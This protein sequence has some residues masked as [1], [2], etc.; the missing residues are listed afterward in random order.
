MLLFFFCK[1]WQYFSQIC[2][3]WSKGPSL[4]TAALKPSHSGEFCLPIPAS[5]GVSCSWSWLLGWA[6]FWRRKEA[7]SIRPRSTARKRGVWPRGVQ[8]STESGPEAGQQETVRRQLVCRTNVQRIQTFQCEFQNGLVCLDGCFM[9]SSPTSAVQLWELVS[10]PD[11]QIFQELLITWKVI[12]CTCTKRN[13]V[14]KIEGS[15][16]YSEQQNSPGCR[17]C[18]LAYLALSQWRSCCWLQTRAPS[19]EEKSTDKT[20]QGNSSLPWPK[21]LGKSSNIL[22]KWKQWTIRWTYKYK[23]HS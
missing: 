18:I 3:L 21:W 2:T 20:V 13:T 11:R 19:C 4:V 12:I 1:S 23:S 8:Q 16:F 22:S 14:W 17:L 6:P 9:E 10:V 15:K 5:N 7:F